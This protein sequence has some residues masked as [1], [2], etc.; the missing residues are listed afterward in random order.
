[1]TMGPPTQVTPAGLGDYL[2]VMSRAVFQTGI[3]WK[4]AAA[5]SR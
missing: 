5:K 4:V 3:S 1:M 2:D